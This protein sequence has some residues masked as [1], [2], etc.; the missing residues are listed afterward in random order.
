MGQDEVRSQTEEYV[1]STERTLHRQASV[2]RCRDGRVGNREPQGIGRPGEGTSTARSQP[3]N[4]TL[5]RTRPP[6]RG[7]C[8]ALQPPSVQTGKQYAGALFLSGQRSTRGRP[9]LLGQG[10]QDRARLSPARRYHLYHTRFPGGYRTSGRRARTRDRQS[11][12]LESSRQFRPRT[13]SLSGVPPQGSIAVARPR[14]Q[15]HHHGRYERR[16]I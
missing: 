7:M 14:V 10:R 1:E 9:G 2:G 8:R 16:S 6:R 5:R 13:C 3:A 4:R 15:N 11:L 12:A